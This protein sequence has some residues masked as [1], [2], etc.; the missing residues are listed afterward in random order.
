[1]PS[2]DVQEFRQALADAQHILVLSGAG[3]S[4]SSGIATFRG[5]GGM[6]RKYDSAS[7]ATLA[8]WQENQSRVWQFFHYRREEIRKASPN[9]GHRTL[10]RLAI[11]SL[12][13][14]VSPSSTFVHVTQNID[15]LSPAALSQAASDAHGTPDGEV[16]EMHG[17][18]FDVVCCAH[19]CDYTE[20]ITRSPICDALAGT[21]LLVEAGDVEPVVKR[22]DLP[23][24]PKC[25]QLVRPDV[26]LFQ[27]RPKRIHEILELA[28]RADLCIVVGTSAVVQP[29]S[30][31]G[32][33]VQAHGGKVVVFNMEMSNHADQA[34]FVF[35]GPCEE[36]L[37]EI[38]GV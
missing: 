17:N 18:I 35:L 26:I 13:K 32:E 4:V 31:I 24:C 20:R 36:T 33:R 25:G 5:K 28:D 29:A 8:A 1:M 16:I 38:I 11:P 3:L 15:G 30:R 2:S 23:H 12:R 19:D 34:D 6:W 21:E 27:E 37:R 7:L 14:A 9:E 10:A 22:A